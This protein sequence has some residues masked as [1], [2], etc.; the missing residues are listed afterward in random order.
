MTLGRNAP[1]MRAEIITPRGFHTHGKEFFAAAEAVHASPKHPILP[2]AF[3]W[4]RAIELLLKSYLLSVGVSIERLRSRQF[5]HNLVALHK[6]AS[7]RGLGTLIGSEP[8]IAGLVQLLNF[9]YGSKRL[10]YRESGTKYSIPDAELAR[11]VIRRLLKGINFHL[12][13]NGI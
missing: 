2:L 13:Q 5:G 1:N 7:A 9:E 11:R 4:G 6:E 8:V 12:L 3:L 10:E